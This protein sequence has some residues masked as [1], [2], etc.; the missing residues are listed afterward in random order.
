MEKLSQTQFGDRKADEGFFQQ[1][2]RG[3]HYCYDLARDV[4]DYITGGC[5][6]ILGCSGDKLRNGGI[7]ALIQRMHP[8]DVEW[9]CDEVESQLPEEGCADRLVYRLCREDGQYVQVF[10][11]RKLAEIKEGYP[12]KMV[13]IICLPE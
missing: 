11:L 6:S 8:E 3:I 12:T 4:Y 13:G 1:W 5:E 7:E 9:I 2:H 10:E